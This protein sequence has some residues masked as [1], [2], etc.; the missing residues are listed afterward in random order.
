MCSALVIARAEEPDGLT[1]S[2][3][4]CVRLDVKK[5]LFV[6]RDLKNDC[7]GVTELEM[8]LE[9]CVEL[10][11]AALEMKSEISCCAFKLVLGGSKER[12]T[13]RDAS[14]N[15]QSRSG[16]GRSSLLTANSPA[17]KRSVQ[18]R[19]GSIIS[20]TLELLRAHS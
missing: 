1:Q 2:Q 13:G 11:P 5:D 19:K 12:F 6:I 7:S 3:K 14:F 17:K 15:D 18:A 8:G 4:G 10:S 20:S 16:N 9:Y